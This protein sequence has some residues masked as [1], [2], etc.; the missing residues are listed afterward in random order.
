MTEGKTV[1]AKL[2]NIF[3]SGEISF[4]GGTAT[5]NVE[6]NALDLQAQV[7]S[8]FEEMKAFHGCGAKFRAKR[9]VAVR[10]VSKN[11]ENRIS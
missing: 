2:A 7:R 8:N 4:V 6:R 5:A 10:V 9:L 11:A 3:K 1:L